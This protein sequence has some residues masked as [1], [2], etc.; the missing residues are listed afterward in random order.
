MSE[1]SGPIPFHA[2]RAYAIPQGIR[3]PSALT[4]GRRTILPRQDDLATPTGPAV[5]SPG[6]AALVAARVPGSIDFTG[7]APAATAPSHAL[8]FY[9]HPTDK[10]AAATGL[11]AGRLI[12]STA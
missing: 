6:L 4:P 10:N 1:I 3:E 9:R 2:A 8:P 7:C 5:R 12:D 11:T